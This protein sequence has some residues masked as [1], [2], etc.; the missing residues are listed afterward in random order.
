MVIRGQ[1]LGDRMSM[2]VMTRHASGFGPNETIFKTKSLLLQNLIVRDNEFTLEEEKKQFNSLCG[3]MSLFVPRVI[4]L[5]ESC[6]HIQYVLQQ[7]HSREQQTAKKSS[8]RTI[9]ISEVV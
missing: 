5:S 2:D 8:V 3:H 6:S 4:S 1:S 9:K 7:H